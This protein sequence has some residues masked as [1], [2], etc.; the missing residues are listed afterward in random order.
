[1]TCWCGEKFKK[2]V[3]NQLYHSGECRNRWWDSLKTLK[4]I[5]GLCL[6]CQKPYNRNERLSKAGRRK[7]RNSFCCDECEAAHGDDRR[8]KKNAARDARRQEET[9][10]GNWTDG[11]NRGDISE[12]FEA[13][14]PRCETWHTVRGIKM[15]Y[16]KK[17]RVYCPECKKLA[18]SETSYYDPHRIVGI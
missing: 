2:T 17:Q 9:K 5:E 4:R 18:Q 14:C 15:P 7:T 1:M 13:F 3:A 11:R 12:T 8:K 10:K 6:W 16:T